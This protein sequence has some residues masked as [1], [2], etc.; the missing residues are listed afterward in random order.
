MKS[1]SWLDRFAWLEVEVLH[2]TPFG[3]L[4]MNERGGGG[5]SDTGRRCAPASLAKLVSLVS[6]GFALAKSFA[7]ARWASVEWHIL[8]CF[9]VF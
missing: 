1:E 3:C 7:N 2:A 4:R 9:E 5:E 6:A 8:F